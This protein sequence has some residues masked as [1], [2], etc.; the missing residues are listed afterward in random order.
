MVTG[1]IIIFLVIAVFIAGIIYLIDIF[2]D[3]V[4]KLLVWLADILPGCSVIRCE[5]PQ[6]KRR[7]AGDD[8]YCSVCG[9]WVASA[10]LTE[11][12]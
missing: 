1:E 2:A 12:E 5:H 6:G 10:D 8:V 11:S 7:L 3:V 4:W 9:E